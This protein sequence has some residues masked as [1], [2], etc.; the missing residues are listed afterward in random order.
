MW[1]LPRSG[2]AATPNKIVTKYSSTTF[3]HR[4][5]DQAKKTDNESANRRERKEAGEKRHGREK[6]RERKKAGVQRSGS[7]KLR[8]RN[9][10]G[11][12]IK[13]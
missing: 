5:F 13:M 9:E 2:N 10:Q 8:Y 1:G 6:A 7:T 3:Q 4:F 12:S 11:E